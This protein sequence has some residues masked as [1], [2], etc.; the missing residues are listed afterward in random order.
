MTPDWLSELEYHA[1]ECIPELVAVVRAASE[2]HRWQMERGEPYRIGQKRLCWCDRL[3][4][5]TAI[6]IDALRTRVTSLPAPPVG[7]P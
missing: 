5:P 4:C 1:R 7:E 6:A 3:E 2:I